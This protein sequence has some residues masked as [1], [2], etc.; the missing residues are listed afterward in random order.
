MVQKIRLQQKQAGKFSVVP[1]VTNETLV[2]EE[3]PAVNAGN[4]INK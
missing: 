1:I 4:D 3:T 2:A